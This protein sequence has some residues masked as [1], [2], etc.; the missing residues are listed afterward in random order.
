MNDCGGNPRKTEFFPSIK[1]RIG[2]F[3]GFSA[4]RD[5]EKLTAAQAENRAFVAPKP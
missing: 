4:G 2:G 5:R 1:R 3:A